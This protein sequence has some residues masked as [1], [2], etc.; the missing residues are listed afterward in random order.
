MHIERTLVIIKPDCLQRNLVGEVIGRLEHKGLKL[1]GIKML[2]LSDAILDKHYE[3]LKD[4]PFFPKIK[5]FMKSS[6][7][8]VMVWEGITA[9]NVVRKLA[10]ITKSREADPGTIRGDFALSQQ[11]N[12]IHASDSAET[13]KAEIERLFETFEIF[14]YA[15]ID[16]DVTHAEDERAIDN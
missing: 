13:A 8:I 6:P 16:F 7:C 5:N 9:I 12:I 2:E 15:K 11:Y 14:E 1:L 10:G 4:K 3:H